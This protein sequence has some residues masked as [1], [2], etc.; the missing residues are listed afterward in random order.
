MFVRAEP[1]SEDCFTLGTVA[2]VRTD[3]SLRVVYQRHGADEERI[4]RMDVDAWP[5]GGEQ[6]V[7]SDLSELPMPH[8]PAI[9]HTLRQRFENEAA[10]GSWIGPV[11]LW[12]NPNGP[13]P[14]LWS[15]QQ[16]QAAAAAP[17]ATSSASSEAPQPHPYMV[18]ERCL[19]AALGRDT[20][21]GTTARS[22]AVVVHGETGAGQSDIFT[23]IAS[24]WL[25]RTASPFGAAAGLVSSVSGAARSSADG[26]TAAARSVGGE[27]AMV[28]AH[29]EVALQAF[30]SCRTRRHAS[31]PRF[32]R[33]VRVA[34]DEHGAAMSAT[35][36]TFGLETSRVLDGDEADG[37]F[38]VYYSVLHVGSLRYGAPTA[39]AEDGVMGSAGASS[40]PA[41]ASRASV[42]PRDFAMLRSHATS[43]EGARRGATDLSKLREALSG[44]GM[45]GRETSHMWC[46]LE[47][48]LHLSNLVF[49]AE[50]APTE[51][52]ATAA[53]PPIGA[54]AVPTATATT[55]A[56]NSSLDACAALLGMPLLATMLWEAEA[57]VSGAHATRAGVGVRV[58]RTPQQ[59][60][61][62]R[63]GLMEELHAML[64][65]LITSRL[66][67]AL[68]N[69]LARRS[70]LA[71]ASSATDAGHGDGFGGHRPGAA[72]ASSASAATELALLEPPPAE[73]AP[74]NG[75]PQ[76]LC[77]YAAERLHELFIGRA[78]SDEQQRY[79][80]EG[81]GWSEVP[82]PETRAILILLDGR[83]E[84]HM[85]A[86]PPLKDGC[87]AGSAAASGSAD[88]GGVG[89]RGGAAGE[90]G[91]ADGGA[92]SLFALL[93]LQARAAAAASDEGMAAVRFTSDLRR[94]HATSA[95]FA[96]ADMRRARPRDSGQWGGRS[97]AAE[98]GSAATCFVIN[99]SAGSAVYDAR[100]LLHSCRGSTL[101]PRARLLLLESSNILI[102]Q[103]AD[104]Y[105]PAANGRAGRQAAGGA[106]SVLGAPR[107]VARS[108]AATFVAELRAALH[109][110]ERCE[111]RHVLCVAPNASEVPSSF[112]PR[113]VLRQLDA[114]AVPS[115]AY[116]LANGYPDRLPLLAV[117]GRLRSAAPPGWA[118]LSPRAFVHALLCASGLRHGRHFQIGRTAALVRTQRRWGA[119]AAYANVA[120]LMAMSEPSARA[121][122][123]QL[124]G[125]HVR[126]Q[127]EAVMLL[128][129][130]ARRWIARYRGR[131]HPAL[132]ERPGPDNV[133]QPKRQR[134][135]PA[136]P[137]QPPMIRSLLPPPPPRLP[138]APE[139]P[140]AN[141]SAGSSGSAGAGASTLG[142]GPSANLTE[143]DA[144]A[145]AEAMA[146]AETEA[147]PASAL[148]LADLESLA[149]AVVRASAPCPP[150]WA[151]D[152]PLGHARVV[153]VNL[154]RRPPNGSGGQADGSTA[155]SRGG[156]KSVRRERDADG[157]G[158][159]NGSVLRAVTHS[160]ERAFSFG[161]RTM[162]A[163]SVAGSARRGA[164]ASRHHTGTPRHAEGGAS[165]AV[166]SRGGTQW[167]LAAV[168]DAL[169]PA[170]SSAVA[171]ATGTDEDAVGA[172]MPRAWRGSPSSYG[173]A[174]YLPPPSPPTSPPQDDVYELP[175]AAAKGAW[176]KPPSWL[177]WAEPPRHVTGPDDVE[178]GGR[179]RGDRRHRGERHRSS[180]GS[181]CDASEAHQDSWADEETRLHEQLLQYNKER[182][183]HHS[184][185]GHAHHHHQ[186][187]PQHNP[188]PHHHHTRK[189]HRRAASVP[190]PRGPLS[191]HHD[192][193]DG[194][195]GGEADE[196]L[197]EESS[198]QPASQ[199]ASRPAGQPAGRRPP[200][201]EPA[202][203]FGAYTPGGAAS[204]SGLVGG[205]CA[206][207][208]SE[209]HQP[210][211]ATPAGAAASAA[212]PV[213]G[214]GR[215][216][217]FDGADIEAADV[218]NLSATLRE[219]SRPALTGAHLPRLVSLPDPAKAVALAALLG[220]RSLTSLTLRDCQLGE[221]SGLT[222]GQL[223][224]SGVPIVELDLRGN[225]LGER[226]EWPLL[227]I[228][229]ERTAPGHAPL[230]QP[231]P[232]TACAIAAPS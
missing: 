148:T 195:S 169:T 207:G 143:S 202:R 225:A 185:H 121:T 20:V 28:L 114:L 149:D 8:M 155:P 214:C 171:A 106:H 230:C 217:S 101:P 36:S 124:H 168:L 166:N 103:I 203:G 141:G 131:R 21:A 119:A 115:A 55:A 1:W 37:N 29:G 191:A 180:S 27:A 18:G 82:L 205:A 110:C 172:M 39:A 197:R 189:H 204:D 177:S 117:T 100:A 212:P 144:A 190:S 156:W 178:A 22:Q 25:W 123:S 71:A 208:A 16:M 138:G 170:S 120:R 73:I 96:D 7:S 183:R 158:G 167:G 216:A 157:G 58:R 51:P 78:L 196:V 72:A 215:A 66:N 70:A 201:G 134:G 226:G 30:G 165:A 130:W 77:N 93:E 162:G 97:A 84:M 50:G 43:S 173:S 198:P 35:L 109:V 145:M 150:E 160:V 69:A 213:A 14:E 151:R 87:A 174:A 9:M 107:R 194:D 125:A 52:T 142:A 127:L 75:L 140:S 33:C 192:G 67:T 92:T 64:F 47:G 146:M 74:V 137:S 116:L 182:R 147:G 200:E 89:G 129:A 112:E 26:A 126:R 63:R 136:M 153:L 133:P 181:H 85:R 13:S 48:M 218:S 199:P 102:R 176:L 5:A 40:K 94:A 79:L 95:A 76:L 128:A 91:G 61:E 188:S 65:Q 159:G 12:L 24:F 113:V 59:A 139:H 44:L 41:G 232:R 111:L 227:T 56:H 57:S 15:G 88:A 220:S 46:V 206:G 161:R 122:L 19:R 90:G 83:P 60:A 105:L 210:E 152:A 53:R 164:G 42:P 32:G 132:P 231:T 80:E 135:A 49:G 38:H 108:P 228:G 10:C 62:V 31:T 68:A 6:I 45:S 229:A 86:L 99:H 211:L 163:A 186:H 224:S 219:W 154:G 118:Q 23:A 222:L 187:S 3:G 104:G 221:R 2:S 193:N 81:I 184:H 223:L 4:V 209:V 54:D 98:D 11:L 175:G 17:D 179:A 34:L